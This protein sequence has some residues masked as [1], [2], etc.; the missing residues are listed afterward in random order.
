MSDR[1]AQLTQLYEAF[2]RQDIEAVLVALHP[3][4]DWPDVLEGKRR[5]G[6]DDVRA[7]WL[8]QFKLIRSE[9]AP[10]SFDDLPDGRVRVLVIQTVR[11]VDG[12]LWSEGKVE[13]VYSFDGDLISRMESA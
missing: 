5:H 7:Y 6:R 2:N 4:V 1:E 12:Q 10:L 9:L 11:G 13:H 8:G 3:D